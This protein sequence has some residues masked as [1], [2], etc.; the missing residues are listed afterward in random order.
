M[1]DTDKGPGCL[2]QVVGAGTPAAKAGMKPGDRILE[3]M[4]PREDDRRSTV[5][6]AWKWPSA[7][8]SRT[9]PSNW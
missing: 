6:R 9:R 7:R 5:R 3:L 1:D 2:V 8:P 4:L